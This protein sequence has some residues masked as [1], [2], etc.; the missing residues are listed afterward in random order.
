LLMRCWLSA[1]L[2]TYLRHTDM[3]TFTTEDREG[4]ELMALRMQQKVSE[5]EV[6]N[7]LLKK[8]NAALKEHIRHLE[9]QVYGGTTK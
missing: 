7:F 3:T 4:E 6:D 8:E 9:S 2:K 1:R 5:L